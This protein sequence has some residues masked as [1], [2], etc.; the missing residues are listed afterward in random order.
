MKQIIHNISLYVLFTIIVLFGFINKSYSDTQNS[1]IQ[2]AITQLCISEA[3]FNLK[4]N[5]C[6]L[7]YK[8][9]KDRS[10]R[11]FNDSSINMRMIRAY[12]GNAL[13]K[14]RRGIRSWIPFLNHNAEQPTRW[15]RRTLSW[16]LYRE[17]YKQIYNF[18]G[19]ILTNEELISYPCQ[20]PVH[21]WAKRQWADH[22]N[23]RLGWRYSSCPNTLNQFWTV[24]E[25]L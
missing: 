6:L 23:R 5:D 14:N 7:I 10:Q 25:F 13:N 15:P 24:P 16:S 22:R 8:V 1:R 21:H 19:K 17:Q 12:S 11:V 4:S 2:L 20:F 9:L 3:G 18:V